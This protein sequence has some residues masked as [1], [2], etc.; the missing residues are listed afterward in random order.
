[1]GEKVKLSEGVLTRET[2]IRALAVG[3]QE[4]SLDVGSEDMVYPTDAKMGKDTVT[5][6]Y[7]NG[8]TVELTVNVKQ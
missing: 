7:T 4:L 2:V 5:V 1:M 6:E 8:S 3:L